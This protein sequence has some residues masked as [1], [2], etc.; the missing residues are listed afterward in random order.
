[1]LNKT[2]FLIAFMLI[3]V[4]LYSQ[5]DEVIEDNNEELVLMNLVSTQEVVFELRKNYGIK[6]SVELT[7]A[8]WQV[9]HSYSNQQQA[10]IIWQSAINKATNLDSILPVVV[11]SFY[12]AGEVMITYVN[13]MSEKKWNKNRKLY[14]LNKE[15]VDDFLRMNDDLTIYF[16]LHPL[17]DLLLEG[18]DKQKNI[19]WQAVFQKTLKVYQQKEF[20]EDLDKE[21]TEK[22]SSNQNEADLTDL[23]SF[24]SDLNT[25]THSED[26]VHDLSVLMKKVDLIEAKHL[27]HALIRFVLAKDNEQFLSSAMS[28]FALAQEIIAQADSFSELELSFYQQFIEEN[29]AWFLTKE[30]SLM[31]VDTRLPELVE[32][33]FHQLK[34]LVKKP[35]N[36]ANVK[37]ASV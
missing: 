36:L 37:L 32:L 21:K 34:S 33:S 23:S 30:Q 1:M 4:N 24:V 11:S 5:E 25:W 3:S 28:W 13:G 9:L 6:A 22:I 15:K 7:R 14:V 8:L 18:V 12:N 17:W 26:R 19:D 27:S 31:D 2:Y 16:N 10:Q 20:V 29:D 35:H